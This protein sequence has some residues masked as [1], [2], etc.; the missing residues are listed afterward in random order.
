MTGIDD[1]D[2]LFRLIKVQNVILEAA[3]NGAVINK[4]SIRETFLDLNF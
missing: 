1:Y 2:H 3:L 4:Q